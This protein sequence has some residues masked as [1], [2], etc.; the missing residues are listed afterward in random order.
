MEYA[1]KLGDLNS[2]SEAYKAFS[3]IL[4]HG[5]APSDNVLQTL[6]KIRW[7]IKRKAYREENEHRLILTSTN[8]NAISSPLGKTKVKRQFFGAKSEVRDYIEVEFGAIDW[9]MLISDVVIGPKNQTNS[10]VLQDFL[11]ANGLPKT[12]IRTS[13]VH[14]R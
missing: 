14:Y 9:E 3:T 5:G 6:A 13:A 1:D 7:T 11:I 12:K 8:P 4:T 10:S 2:N